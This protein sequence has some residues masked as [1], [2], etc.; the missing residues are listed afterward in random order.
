VTHTL[1]LAGGRRAS[2][3]KL[4]IDATG[5]DKTKLSHKANGALSL[6]R[7][8]QKKTV[9]VYQFIAENTVEAKVC[10]VQM[11]SGLTVIHR[12]SPG[13]RNTGQ[14]KEADQRGANPSDGTNQSV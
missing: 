3:V 2:R 8:G 4:L 10:S 7:I 1:Y 14:E 11:L 13:S 5:K 12:L 9:H 6:Y